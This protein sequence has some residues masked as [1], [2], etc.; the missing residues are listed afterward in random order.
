MYVTDQHGTRRCDECGYEPEDGHNP[1][2]HRAEQRAAE[3]AYWEPPE[4][5]ADDRDEGPTDV[6]CVRCGQWDDGM[7]DLLIDGEYQ[8]ICADCWT[9]EE[10]AARDAVFLG[11]SHALGLHRA[12]GYDGDCPACLVGDQPF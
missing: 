12:A 1:E 10:E 6:Q 4:Y 11:M 8:P 3:Y 5:D 2:V 9:P 7:D